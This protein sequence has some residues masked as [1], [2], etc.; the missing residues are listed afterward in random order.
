MSLEIVQLPSFPT[1]AQNSTKTVNLQGAFPLGYEVHALDVIFEFTLNIN[2]STGTIVAADH[3]TIVNAL[4]SKLRLSAYG[5]N[6]VYNLT[7]PENRILATAAMQRDPFTESLKIG[8]GTTTTPVAYK[9]KLEIPFIHKALDYPEMFC[10]YSDQLNLAGTKIDIDTGS[11]S[12]TT[13]SVGGGASTVVVTDVKLFMVGVPV[14]VPHVGPAMYYKSKSISQNLDIEYG[15][16]CDIFVADER[17]F[18]TTEVQVQT[19]EILRDQRSG[20][21]NISPTNLAQTYA[22]WGTNL[23]AAAPLDITANTT[24]TQV[25]PFIFLNSAIRSTEWQLPFYMQ[26][27]TVR[28]NLASGGSPNATFLFWQVRPINEVQQQM[29]AIAAANGIAVSSVDQ[30]IV[31]GGGGA[32]NDVNKLFKGRYIALRS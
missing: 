18:A 31:R 32:D 30:L 3:Q 25:T 1:Y 12:L 27:R 14:A 20:P 6:D 22:R 26:N 17:A 16:A 5:Q 23:D 29:I 19:Y 2:A 4:L 10:P 11:A 21:K 28:Q 13:I 9:L 15:P 24:G 7:G 8:Q